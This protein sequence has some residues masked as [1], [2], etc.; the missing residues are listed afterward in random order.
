MEMLES[1]CEFHKYLSLSPNSVNPDSPSPYILNISVVSPPTESVTGEGGTSEWS[2]A[3][4]N[5]IGHIALWEG[6]Y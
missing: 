5:F 1:D 2:L 4:A 3:F 6:G